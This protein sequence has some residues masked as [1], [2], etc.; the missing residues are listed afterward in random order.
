MLDARLQP[1]RKPRQKQEI[2]GYNGNV[3]SWL[4]GPAATKTQRTLRPRYYCA[5]F[6]AL[7]GHTTQKRSV[8]SV[9]TIDDP[10][11]PLD[12]HRKAH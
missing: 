8:S 5:H 12:G 7:L 1:F 11:R 3:G 4:L 10:T 2:T 9:L 6:W